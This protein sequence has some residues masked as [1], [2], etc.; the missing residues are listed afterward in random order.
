MTS[1]VRMQRE[2]A[3]A[4][5]SLPG[6]MPVISLAVGRSLADALETLAQDAEV[7]VVVLRGEQRQ[8][9]AGGDIVAIRDGLDDPDRVL[10]PIIDQLHRAMRTIQAMPQPVIASVAGAAAGAG[11]SLAVGCDL[12]V[13]AADARFI[14]GYPA[15]GTSSDGGLSHT[16]TRRLGPMRALDLILARGSFDADEALG[17]GLAARV[18]APT[19]LE[20]ETADY[21]ARIAAHPAASVR[22]FKQLVARTD[23]EALSAALDA[24]KAA[25][26]RCAR[27]PEFAARV[28]AFLERR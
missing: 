9:C 3:V 17:W 5:L 11:L 1:E 25:F 15:L 16:L 10:G 13:C 8:F 26:L 7:R 28:R 14:V 27:T 12:M 23:G 6:R 4:I 24:E 21:A 19:A 18:A 2:G 22:A 20:A